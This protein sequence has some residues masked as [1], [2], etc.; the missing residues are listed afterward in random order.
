MAT[1]A[2]RIHNSEGT[3]DLIYALARNDGSAHH[4]YVNAPFLVEGAQ[5]SRNLADAVHY[6]C[7][8]HG[9]LPSVVDLAAMKAGREGLSGWLNEAAIAFALERT[10]LTRLVVAVGPM[11]STPGQADCEAAVVSQHHAL[12]M[13][14]RSER[15][16]CAIGA[17]VGLVL[18]WAAVRPILDAAAARFG[19]PVAEW[20][21]PPDSETRAFINRIADTYTVERAMMFGAQQLLAQHRGLWDLLEARSTARQD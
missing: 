14:A 6:L 16:G 4:E 11:P 3:A 8:L 10:Y 5:S 20:R 15:H 7:V 2:M 12:E 19:L 13:L 17:A 9:R 21:L 1:D 18:D